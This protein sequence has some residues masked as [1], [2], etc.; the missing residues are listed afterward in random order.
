[1]A[2]GGQGAPIV[3]FAHWFFGAARNGARVVVNFGGICNFTFVARDRNDV[4]AYDVGPAMMLSDYCSTGTQTCSANVPVSGAEPW[5]CRPVARPPP[6][7]SAVVS[8]TT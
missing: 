2:I 1:M 8:T 3:P 6:R 5:R 4:V 7:T